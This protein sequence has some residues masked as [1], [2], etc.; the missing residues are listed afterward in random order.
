MTDQEVNKIIAEFMGESAEKLRI[1]Q[2]ATSKE[3]VSIT[4]D[5]PYLSLD[6]L[7]PVWEKLRGKISGYRNICIETDY[8]N[9]DEDGN[10]WRF[11]IN[12]AP[13]ISQTYES[14]Q[15]AAAHAT[16]KAI[17]GLKKE[18]AE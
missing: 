17:L 11:G 2:Y 16:A 9:F 6:A 1:E 10:F 5:F 8:L 4:L 14:I 3:S 7:V 12:C 13:K 18:S 15:Q